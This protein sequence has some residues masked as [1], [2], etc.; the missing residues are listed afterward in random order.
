MLVSLGF[1]RRTLLICSALI[2]AVALVLVAGVI[3]SVKADTFSA[4]LPKQAAAGSRQRR[5]PSA[6]AI[7]LCFG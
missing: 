5:C 1:Y 6:S 7:S 4:A 2:I 3:L